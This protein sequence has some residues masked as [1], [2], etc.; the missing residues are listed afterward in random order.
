MAGRGERLHPT[1]TFAP[2]SRGRRRPWLWF[3]WG[4]AL[5]LVPMLLW[6]LASPLGSSPDEPTHFVRAAAVARGEILTG[7]LK[8]NPRTSAVEVPEYVAATGRVT[9]YAFKPDVPASC[10]PPPPADPDRIVEAGHTAAA[11]SPVFYA[12]TGLPSLVLHGHAALYAMRGV[13]SVLCALT[14]GSLFFCLALLARPRWSLLAGVTAVTPMMLFLGGTLNPN[15]VEASATASLFA[16]LSVLGLRALPD[17]LLWAVSGLAALSVVLLT[18]TRNISLLWGLIVVAIALLFSRSPVL[19]RLVRKPALWVAAGVAV[20]IAGAA[21]IY[22]LIPAR[23]AAPQQFN[24]A[25][26]TFG[27]GFAYMIQHTFDF[28]SGWIGL[29][30]WVDTPAPSYTLIVWGAVAVGLVAGALL[31]ASRLRRVGLLIVL[32][33]LVLVPALAQAA[34]ITAAGM[35]WQGRYTLALFLVLV[36]ASGIA[37]DIALPAPALPAAARAVT[38]SI[39]LLAVGQFV[40]FVTA[41]KRYVV[42]DAAY[43]SALFTQP[44]WRPPTGWITLTVL[45]ALTVL[46]GA[47]VATRA[48]RRLDL[49]F[50]VAQAVADEPSIAGR[51]ASDPFPAGPPPAA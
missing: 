25:G 42:G 24:G 13:N 51:P 9:C 4:F 22:F 37:L 33:A 27:D 32:A 21:L 17:R 1:G 11:N 14:F 18:G 15:G 44:A 36:I 10:V 50:T 26:S 38:F 49:R 19:K 3:V 41:L 12:L 39:W 35:I 7:P 8:A 45:M 46:L 30:G 28:A 6:N 34:V 48:S 20:V 23:T 29:F 47:I 16:A 31:F 5:T 40:A 43:L 2:D